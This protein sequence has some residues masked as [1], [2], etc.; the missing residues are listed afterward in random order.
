MRVG[1]PLALVCLASLASGQS[2]QVVSIVDRSD[3]EPTLQISG[4]V[5]IS[6]QFVGNELI[7]SCTRHASARNISQKPIVAL[8]LTF[9]GRGEHSWCGQATHTMENFWSHRRIEPEQTIPIWDETKPSG[10]TV[11][12]RADPLSAPFEP[13]AEIRLVFVQF[14]DGT[15]RGDVGAAKDLFSARDSALTE[16]LHLDQTYRES[17]AKAFSGELA[18]VNRDVYLIPEIQRIAQ[19]RGTE[20]AIERVQHYLQVAQENVS[21]LHPSKAGE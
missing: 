8:I 11:S 5:S 19:T 21:A 3:I 16:L 9:E 12:Y 2:T 1:A 18:G 14:A 10:R 4:T 13:K 20:A 15:V 6:G 7:S 17:G